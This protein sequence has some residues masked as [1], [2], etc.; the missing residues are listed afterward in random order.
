MSREGSSPFV[1][2]RLRGLFQTAWGFYRGSFGRM[3]P[4]SLALTVPLFLVPLIAFT[5]W[6]GEDSSDALW[7][8]I[9][10]ARESIFQ[11][12]G[13][14]MVGLGAV[15]MT[16][17]LRERRTTVA[18]ARLRVRPQRSSLTV[19]ALYSVMLGLAGQLL[20]MFALVLPLLVLG[21]PILVHVVTLENKT[22]PEAVARTRALLKGQA[23]RL[24]GSLFPLILIMR[25]LELVIY[26]AVFGMLDALGVEQDAALRILQG[27]LTGL[28]FG[29]VILPFTASLSLAA[30]LD[31]RARA[32]RFDL[33]TLEAE[34]L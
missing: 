20:P 12:V 34:A 16:D 7:A 4:P 28:L 22:V 5:L 8:G 15:I 24:L 18:E 13:S 21:P 29:L 33:E 27:V 14:V 17:G 23:L 9:F 10:F 2:L 6:R 1:P 31:L 30:Y 19:V 3:A 11:F 26:F 25:F 32:E